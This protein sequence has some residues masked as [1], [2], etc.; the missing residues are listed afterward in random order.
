MTG[1]RTSVDASVAGDEPGV[2]D[3]PT[4]FVRG[5]APPLQA[6]AEGN[7]LWQTG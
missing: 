6:S 1:L 7:W 3:W 5:N 2:A 4:G